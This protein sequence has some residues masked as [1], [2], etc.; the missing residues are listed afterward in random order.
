VAKKLIVFEDEEE[1]K[2]AAQKKAKRKDL[3]L[4]QVLRRLLRGWVAENS[5]EQDEG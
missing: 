3:S 5:D 1:I 2:E 4:S